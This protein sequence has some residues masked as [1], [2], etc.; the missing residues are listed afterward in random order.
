MKL[1]KLQTVLRVSLCTERVGLLSNA[2]RYTYNLC[3][4]TWEQRFATSHWWKYWR[5]QFQNVTATRL[6]KMVWIGCIW[7]RIR[8]SGGSLCKR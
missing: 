1:L 7:L 3:S 5:G 4:F 8:S 6:C 2:V